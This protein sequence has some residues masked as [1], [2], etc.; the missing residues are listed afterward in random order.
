MS[1]QPLHMPHFET[2]TI[3]I[4]DHKQLWPSWCRSLRNVRPILA[5]QN[6]RSCSWVRSGTSKNNKIRV[7]TGSRSLPHKRIQVRNKQTSIMTWLCSHDCTDKRRSRKCIQY[8][9][10]T[11]TTSCIYNMNY[12]LFWGYRSCLIYLIHVFQSLS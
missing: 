9:N 3:K 7:N 10:T 6:L 4:P 2:E 12:V 1:W 8:T 11:T 5:E